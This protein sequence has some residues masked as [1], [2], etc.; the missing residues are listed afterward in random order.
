MP[1]EIV[2][3]LL[4]SP[5]HL[6][7]SKRL[8]GIVVHYEHAS[9]TISVR[10]AQGAHVDAVGSAVEGVGAA[11]ARALMQLVGF[12]H[13]DDLGMLRIRLGVDYVDTRGLKARDQ[14]IPALDVRV[15]RVGA[16][17]R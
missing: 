5:I 16:Q 10:R 6:P 3:E 13:L 9:R 4:R 12:D 1:P 14:Q 2:G 15:W 7:S 8:E 11:V 17:R